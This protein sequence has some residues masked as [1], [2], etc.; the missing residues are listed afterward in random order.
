MPRVIEYLLWPLLFGG[1]V[2]FVAA[3]IDG[4]HPV[5]WFNIVYLVFAIAIALLERL[6][7]HERAWLRRDGQ[8]FANIAHT[9]LSKGTVQIAVF[10]TISVGL[11]DA[12]NS[13]EVVPYRIWPHGWPMIFQV[14]L[15]LVIAEFGLYQAHRLSHTL[16]WLWRF[17]A[18]HHSVTRLWFINTGRFHVVDT[19]VSI[20]LSQPLLWLAGAPELMFIWVG[21]ITAFIGMLTHCNIAMRFG[22]ISWIF[23]TPE[24]HR[25][26]H[27]PDRLEGNTNFGENLMLFD[28]L[29]G[30]FYN[31]AIRPPV[32][33]GLAEPM[34]SGFLA[35]LRYPFR[36]QAQD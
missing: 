36:P 8:T 32:Q 33:I 16:G 21:A 27:S 22:P 6:L 19:L 17:H 26:H 23:N 24:L 14:L 34:P 13:A 2:I 10:V 12:F 18:I 5:I 35:Q 9:L 11:A 20:L 7:P 28:L 31:P 1:G 25:W 30:T 29:F 3:G 15:A 4:E